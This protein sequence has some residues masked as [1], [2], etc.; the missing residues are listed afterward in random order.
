MKRSRQPVRHWIPTCAGMTKWGVRLDA[1]IRQKLGGWG[2]IFNRTVIPVNAGIQ[3]YHEA[4][5]SACAALDTRLRGYDEVGSGAG[6]ADPA[7]A[8]RAGV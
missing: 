6:W 2:M 7:E 3:I 4:Q 1:L 8:G 5:P